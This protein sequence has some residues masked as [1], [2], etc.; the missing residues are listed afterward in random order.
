MPASCR[1]PK[2]HPKL[3][4]PWILSTTLLPAVQEGGS[5]EGLTKVLLARQIVAVGTLVAPV[6]Q[7]TVERRKAWWLVMQGGR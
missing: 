4:S 6:T 1:V 7:H 2:A 3:P 5:N